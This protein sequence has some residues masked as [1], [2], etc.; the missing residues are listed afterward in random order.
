MKIKQGLHIAFALLF[1]GSVL[2]AQ[3]PDSTAVASGDSLRKIGPV[4]VTVLSAADS[5]AAASGDTLR[6]IGPVPVTALS[7]TDSLMLV[8]SLSMDQLSQDRLMRAK[9]DSLRGTIKPREK[10]ITAAD[11]R[12]MGDSLRVNYEF[13][14]SINRY[15]KAIEASRDSLFVM[16]VE[17]AM[18]LSQNGLSMMNYC[19]RPVVVT[20]KKFPLEEFFLHYPM[21][22]GAWRRTPN[23]LDSLASSLVGATFVPDSA[24]TIYYS[25]PDK[26]GIRNIYKTHFLDSLWSVPQL[27]NESI[28]SSSDEIY[29]V[30]SQDEKT[31]YF[32][33]KGLYGMGGYDLYMSRW[34]KETWDWETPINMGFPYSSPA[35]DFLF[36]NTD[37]GRYSI[38]ASNRE[39][40]RD[41]VYLYVLEYDSMPLRKA[42]SGAAE[43]RELAALRPQSSV[44]TTAAPSEPEA[45]STSVDIRKYMDKMDDVRALRDSISMYNRE[46]DEMRSKIATVDDAERQS[47][48]TDII[49]REQDLPALQ[50]TLETATRELQSIEMDFLVKGVVID[51]E[52][53]LEEEPEPEVEPEVDFTFADNHFGP[54]LSLDMEVPEPEF[55]YSFMILP[56]GRFAEDN[57][58]PDGLLYQIQFVSTSRKLQPKELKGL[59]PVFEKMSVSLHYTYSVGVF[60]SYNDVLSHLNSVKRLGFRSAFITAF[61]DGKAISVAAARSMEK[62][63]RQM[64]MVEIL[65]D[66]SG[67]LP[68]LALT[69]IRQWTDKDIIRS[70]ESGRVIYKVGPL[71]DREKADAL[72]T[73]LKA[74]GVSRATVVDAG[75]MVVD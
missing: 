33:S 53:F 49:T 75:Q 11:Y 4:P 52:E 23:Q 47:L 43:L 63:I 9:M 35:D 22:D 62:K 6:H 48:L 71:D 74:T 40:S 66:D 10:V 72:V 3:Q 50:K 65:P 30:V 57:T 2:F 69:A 70:E 60:R 19:S 46:L 54:A 38:F 59:S 15:R 26:D 18:S 28:T 21:Q 25:A 39:C 14:K 68:D 73:T 20:K 31:L 32:A 13:Q 41:S 16:D 34:N 45:P 67:S 51:P 24:R 17:E 29:P 12:R 56:E 55:D 44:R 42:V 58:L 5:I 64:Y 8:D 36:Y 7:P 1:S 61:E 37:D 27:L